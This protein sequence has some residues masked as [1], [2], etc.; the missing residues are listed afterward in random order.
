MSVTIVQAFLLCDSVV[1][2]ARSGKAVVQGIFDRIMSKSFPA[3]HPNCSIYARIRLLQGRS[4]EFAIAL[5][6]PSG[7]VERPLPPQKVVGVEGETKHEA[8]AL[9]LEHG[10]GILEIKNVDAWIFKNEWTDEAPAHIEIQ[11]QHQLEACARP[12]AILAVLV[13]GNRLETFVRRRDSEVGAALRQRIRGFWSDL[14]RGILP[15]VILPADAALVSSL[16]RYAEAGNVLDA[17]GNAEIAELCATYQAA[18]KAEREA[19][20]LKQTAKAKLLPLI[21]KAERVLADGYTISCGE[22]AETV[23]EQYTRKS[24]RNFKITAKETK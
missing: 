22:I 1:V 15:P 24:Y 2:D 10:P 17:Q 19:I 21:H 18:A 12:W 20:A 16:Y 23:V 7:G 14:A 13:G 8:Q 4:C 9:Y 6:T 11:V 3:V 5:Q